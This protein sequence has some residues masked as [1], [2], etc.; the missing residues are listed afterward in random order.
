MSYRISLRSVL[1]MFRIWFKLF[2]LL[3]VNYVSGYFC[4]SLAVGVQ[5]TKNGDR[6]LV[7]SCIPE[8]SHFCSSNVDC[9]IQWKQY[10]TWAYSVGFCKLKPRPV[11]CSGC[12]Y[13]WMC[14]RKR[15]RESQRDKGKERYREIETEIQSCRNQDME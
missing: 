4:H 2:T 11:I 1:W 15:D 10:C 14:S 5:I 13:M 8:S 9:I 6:I 7:F 12:M 3:L